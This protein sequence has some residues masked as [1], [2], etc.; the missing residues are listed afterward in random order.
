MKKNI[1]KLLLCIVSFCFMTSVNAEEYSDEFKKITQDGT[2]EFQAIENPVLY[3]MGWSEDDIWSPYLE[4]AYYHLYDYL[5]TISFEEGHRYEVEVEST[6]KAI[7][8]ITSVKEDELGNYIYEEIE[9]HEVTLKWQEADEKLKE[10]TEKFASKLLTN[11][12]PAELGDGYF[13]EDLNLINYWIT[14]NSQFTNMVNFSKRYIDIT[15][16]TKFSMKEDFRMGNDA[17]FRVLSGGMGVIGYDGMDYGYT[18]SYGYGVRNVL[19]IPNTTEETREAHIKAALER[20]K[21]YSPKTSFEIT[22]AGRIEENLTELFD[23]Y[24][25]EGYGDYYGSTSYYYHNTN[26]DYY[27]IKINGTTYPITIVPTVLEDTELPEYNDVDA[28]TGISITSPDSN[29]PLDTKVTVNEVLENTEK[30]EEIKET[31]K[32]DD[33][34]AFDI[35]LYSKTTKENI[36]IGDFSVTIPLGKEYVEK[37]LSAYYIGDKKIEEYLITMD[38]DGNATFRTTHFSTYIIAASG[39][40]KVTEPVP[41]TVDGITLFMGLSIISMIGILSIISYLVYNRKENLE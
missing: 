40:T 29:I 25:D 16:G 22:Y 41:E 36:K 9:K 38:K 2:I 11:L 34:K 6:T 21:N 26:G 14:G 35:S 39:L 12:D 7:I 3:N 17:P 18:G 23:R 4:W 31:L 37:H 32:T 19:Y 28:D 27:Y 33:F 8:S 1:W 24:Y 5:E 15:K 10:E 20:L 13:L 30:H